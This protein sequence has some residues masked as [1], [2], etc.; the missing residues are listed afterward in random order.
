MNGL[1]ARADAPANSP[2]GFPN[3]DL[4]EF[5]SDAWA[6]A[7]YAE[8]FPAF[9]D[10]LRAA[11]AGDAAVADVFEQLSAMLLPSD[12]PEVVAVLD[13]AR[14]ATVAAAVGATGKHLPAETRAIVGNLVREFLADL[15]AASVVDAYAV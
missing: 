9:A 2:L 10:S 3:D 5:F 7:L 8:S 1:L 4:V 11:L 13:A 15:S 14:D 6:Q 12:D